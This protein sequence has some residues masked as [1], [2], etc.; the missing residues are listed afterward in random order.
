MLLDNRRDDPLIAIALT[1][2]HHDFAEA[3]PELS[4]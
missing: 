1:R 2:F 3:D 4:E